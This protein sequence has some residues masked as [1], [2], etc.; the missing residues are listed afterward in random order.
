MI[1]YVIFVQGVPW[2]EAEQCAVDAVMQYAIY[3]LGFQP[4]NIIM[5]G[6]SI[7]GYS[8][9]WAAMNY[10]NIKH[11]VSHSGINKS[12]KLVLKKLHTLQ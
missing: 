6:W 8:V 7:G 12:C 4:E 3:K 2:P 5:F 11:V 9:T 1:C 10:P